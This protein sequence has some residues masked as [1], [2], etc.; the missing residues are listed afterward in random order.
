MLTK[1]DKELNNLSYVDIKEIDYNISLL[2]RSIHYFFQYNKE[3]LFKILYQRFPSII[4]TE[5]RTIYWLSFLINSRKIM[6]FLFAL[7]FR[8]KDQFIDFDLSSYVK[9][10]C[11]NK[12]I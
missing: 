4:I 9:I 8:I 5:H 10:D 6:D 3:E 12:Y 11:N 7:Y 1:I 2:K